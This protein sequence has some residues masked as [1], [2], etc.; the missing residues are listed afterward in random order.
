MRRDVRQ[1]QCR[2]N[3]GL[4][5]ALDV[6]IKRGDPTVRATGRRDRCDQLGVGQL[7]GVGA[8]VSPGG[9]RGGGWAAAPVS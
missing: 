7:E 4:T 2:K 8:A 6:L 3:V 5:L 9:Q 1:A